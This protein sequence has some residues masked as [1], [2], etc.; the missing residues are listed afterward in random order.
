MAGRCLME[1]GQVKK[2]TA[3][4]EKLLENDLY[5]NF[6]GE[7][8]N[9]LATCHT[10]DKAYEPAKKMYLKVIEEYAKTK[11][12]AHACYYLGRLYE[13]VFE[14]MRE[15]FKY[16]K[17]AT[18]EFADCEEA[19]LAK[20]RYE[21]LRAIMFLTADLDSILAA[22]TSLTKEDSAIIDSVRKMSASSK[23]MSVAEVYLYKLSR[24]DSAII[25]YQKIIDLDTAQDTTRHLDKLQMKA[26]YAVA[27]IKKN[28]LHQD[29]EADS[30]FSEIIK[31]YPATEY[32]KAAQL[33]LGME[34]TILT[35]RD[36]VFQR[37]LSAESLVTLNQDCRAAIKSY[38][39]FITAYEEETVA[40]KALLNIAW[41]YE[42]CLFD[43]TAAEEGYKA[44]LEKYPKTGYAQFAKNKL[45][46]K[47]E[48]LKDIFVE[49]PGEGP[50]GT[51]LVQAV[52]EKM[53][54]ITDN[55][56]ET[57]EDEAWVKLVSMD[58]VS[59]KMEGEGR[60][61]EDIMSE[62]SPAVEMLDEIYIDM[63]E[64]DLMDEGNLSTRIWIRRTGEVNKV[65]VDR[66][67]GTIKDKA[68]IEEVENTFYGMEFT[69][70]A[71]ETITLKV[72]MSFTIQAK[73]K[74]TDD[75][76]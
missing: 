14:D 29:K 54:K 15:A 66:G 9:Y 25:H 58:A 28:I 5:V 74:T 30:L 10:A 56:Q 18:T 64:E 39:D 57:A 40:A 72:K 59:G 63:V 3:H 52:A 21:G 24:G 62:L 2:A 34:A 23:Y 6:F 31:A 46:G 68:L 37:F 76:W 12:S 42:T 27:W 38:E 8:Y 61:R 47:K 22:D 20:E 35:R 7:I 19:E 65:R 60:T 51:T 33:A 13:T 36:S 55:V 50:E 48:G 17:Q 70:G 26:V 73:A 71:K 4:F 11:H 53:D 43:N 75:E 1:D 49:K 16:Y 44:L 69:E 67:E 32:A 41:L 45:E